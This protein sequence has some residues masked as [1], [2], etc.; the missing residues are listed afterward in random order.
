MTARLAR[1]LGNWL[2]R[3]VSRVRFLHGTTLC[4]IHRLLFRVP[5]GHLCS[6]GC[7]C[8]LLILYTIAKAQEKKIQAR[9]NYLAEFKAKQHKERAMKARDKQ[10]RIKQRVQAAAEMELRRKITMVRQW[11]ANEKKRVNRLKTEREAKLVRLENEA[12]SKW[13]ARMEAQNTK[14]QE[15]ALLLQLYSEDMAAGARR[16]RKKAEVYAYNTDLELQ[17]IRLANWKLLHGGTAKAVRLVRKMGTEFEKSKRGAK[18][19][20]PH[21]AHMMAAEAMTHAMSTSGDTLMILGQA[22]ARMDMETILP[23]APLH[24]VDEVNRFLWDGNHDGLNHPMTSP[25]LGT[26]VGVSDYY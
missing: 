7:R 19:M 10:N 23:L 13:N 9:M 12:N 21:L 24:I 14:L 4:V 18:G 6:Y 2:P 15:E 11:R 26:R 22:R 8:S 17:R 16:R 25:A 3:N 20:S 5:F 1:W